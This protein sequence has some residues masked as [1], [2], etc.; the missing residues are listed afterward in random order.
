MSPTRAD[1]ELDNL[2]REVTIDAHDEDEQLMGF[3]AAF[4]E[5]ASL[6][7]TVLG[8]EVQVLSVSQADN[9]HELITTCRRGGRPYDI[10]LL[11]TNSTQTLTPHA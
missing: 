9:R 1:P 10:A 8:E 6:P 3:E 11:D 2:I 4:D 7:C 5:D